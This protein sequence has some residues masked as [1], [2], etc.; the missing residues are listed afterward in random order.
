MISYCGNC[1]NCICNINIETETVTRNC[2][3]LMQKVSKEDCCINWSHKTQVHATAD[4]VCNYQDL[5]PNE[6]YCDNAR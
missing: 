6:V 3:I 4:T 2:K 5:C 1:E